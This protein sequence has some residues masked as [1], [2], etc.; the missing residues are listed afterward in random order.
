VDS[1]RYIEQLR[2]LGQP[3]HEYRGIWWR[4]HGSF[5]CKPAL[6]LVEI[7]PG[8]SRP[9]PMKSLAGYAHLVPEGARSNMT[10]HS[11]VYQAR[12]EPFGLESVISKKRNQI[13]KGLRCCE[14]RRI[15]D[16][17]AHWEELRQINISARERTGVGLPG[18]YYIDHY[19]QWRTS[20][21]NL[22]AL[23]DRDWW[24][25]FSQGRLVAYYFSYAVA[26]TVLIDTA[27]THSEFLD[28][29]PTDALLFTLM[30]DAL[31]NKGCRRIFYGDWT[32]DDEK[33]TRFKEQ[34]GFAVKAFPAYR[35][36]SLPA[37]L[38]LRLRR[39][40]TGPAAPEAT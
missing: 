30:E 6:P 29:N 12:G 9:N 16:I 34:H 7:V 11:M 26:D 35:H 22:F 15:G 33:L 3:L 4:R 38:A 10:L 36:L 28:Q 39:R 14:I 23:P 27:K 40:A 24:G 13:R 8:S 21:R 31:N 2:T 32:P 17:E 5:F 19:E 18:T 1:D 20:L 37:R 25:A